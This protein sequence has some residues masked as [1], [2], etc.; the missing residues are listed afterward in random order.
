[1]K[2]EKPL[3]ESLILKEDEFTDLL[4]IEEI[5]RRVNEGSK[6]ELFAPLKKKS[7]KPATLAKLAQIER[8]ILLKAQ[9]KGVF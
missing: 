4:L 5:F 8:K 9:K 1:M 2:A 3:A 7:T 6:V